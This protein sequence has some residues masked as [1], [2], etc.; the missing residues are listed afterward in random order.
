[1]VEPEAA[2]LAA[3]RILPRD[4]QQLE[5]LLHQSQSESI[6]REEF[7]SIDVKFHLLIGAASQN[8]YIANAIRKIRTSINPALDL[9][10]YS[11]EV[12]LNTINH[13]KQLVEAFIKKD[14]R[15]AKETMYAHISGTSLAIAKRI[16]Q[17]N[18]L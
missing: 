14:S 11:D 10:P 4:L 5:Q 17:Q 15:L 3:D 6:M 12:K 9:M 16:S 8:A 13:H 1:M 2:R 18:H 7:R